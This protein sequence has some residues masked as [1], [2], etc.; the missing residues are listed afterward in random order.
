MTKKPVA[1]G[2]VMATTYTA[3]NGSV[4]GGTVEREKALEV[5]LLQI[6]KQ[7]GKGAVMRMG[8]AVAGPIEAIPTGSLALDLAL[9]IGGV[10]RGRVVE[11]FGPEASGK[12]SVSLHIIAEAQRMGGIAAFIDA[13]HALDV[14]YARNLGVNTDELLISQP[15]TGEQGLEIADMLI[16][17]GAIDVVVIDSVAALVPRAEIEGEMGDSHVGLQA[18]LMS[19]ALRKL[20]GTI[21]KSKTTAIFINQ[22]RE[23]VGVLFGSPETTSGGRALKFYSSIRMDIRRIESL[24]DGTEVVGNRT[25]VKV[26]KN[27]CVAAGTTVFDPSTG[28]THRIEDIVDAEAGGSV[29]AVDKLGQLHARPI[30]GRM[31]QGEQ[32]VIGLHLRDGTDLWVTPDHKVLT[33]RGW[34]QAGDL[35]AGDHVARPRRTF[36]FG[37][38]QPIPPDHARLLGYLIGDGYVGGKKPIVFINTEEVLQQDAIGI[39]SSLGCN[40]YRGGRQG[41]ETSFSHRPG[42]KNGVIELVRWAGIWGHLAPTKRIPAPFFA[43]DVSADVIGNL[44]FGIFESDGWVSREQTGGVRCGFTTTSEQLARQ[45]HWLLLRWGIGSSVRSYDPTTRRPSLIGGRR[46]AG[47]LSCWEVRIRGIDNIERFADATPMWGPRGQVLTAELARPEM[48]RY[49][50]SQMV[51]LPPTQREPVLAHLRN[52]GVTPLLAAQLVGEG[53]G[54]PRGGL[55]QVL[56]QSRLRRDRV[57]RLADALEDEFLDTVLNEDLWYAR[58]MALS[59]P[60]RRRTFDI[61]V[62]GL[63]NFVANDVIVHN[64]APPFKQAEFDI[65]YGQGISKEGSL[66]DVGVDVG[67][68]KKSGAWFTY[69]G[70]QLGQGRENARNF[71]RDNPELARE[72]EEKIKAQLGVGVSSD[73]SAEPGGSGELGEEE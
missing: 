11:I 25:R 15:D 7:F 70:D 48:R 33:D 20:A 68:V 17:S 41:I 3:R 1:K 28:L 61:E 52:R 65:I 67:L 6:E 57:Q 8:E 47:K 45:L 63:H 46:V 51:Y 14:A 38:A 37:D 58:V 53:A 27:K 24:K 44:L 9:G 62:E 71:L 36:G 69:E 22:L 30:M 60:E 40:A 21:S 31:D 12:T 39:A 64:C 56:G 42:E 10:P 16:R 19:Q 32:E 43:P 26:V 23:K 35:A 29:M 5:A 50:G 18:R 59:P 49:R 2:T 73:V 54:D 13:E 66:L 55:T 72:I 4:R 34:R